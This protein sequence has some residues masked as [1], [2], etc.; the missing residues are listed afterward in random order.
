MGTPCL[1]LVWPGRVAEEKEPR[2]R[3]RGQEDEG[4]RKQGKRKV[5]WEEGTWSTDTL[6]W[7]G[8]SEG[9]MRAER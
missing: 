2:V 1:Q 3:P 4:K 5:I 7:R 6:R 8:E 9:R